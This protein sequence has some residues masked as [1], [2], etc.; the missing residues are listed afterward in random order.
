M[1]VKAA[2]KNLLVKSKNEIREIAIA[3]YDQYVTVP[4]PDR[5]IK[6]TFRGYVVKAIDNAIADW[7]DDK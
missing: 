5:F 2:V 3:A 4:G 6:S 1:T 7:V